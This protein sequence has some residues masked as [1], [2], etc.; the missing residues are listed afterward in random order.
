[1]AA[2]IVALPARGFNADVVEKLEGLLAQA[3]AGEVQSI[4][5]VC[6]MRD[7]TIAAGWTGCENLY[8]LAGH[9]ARAL[10]LIQ[11]RIDQL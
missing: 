3:K 5:F 11:K 7:Q 2:E 1:M 4:L 9:V 6:D 8:L 10:H